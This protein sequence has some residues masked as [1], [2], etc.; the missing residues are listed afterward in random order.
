MGFIR[1][2]ALSRQ[3]KPLGLTTQS[4][5]TDTFLITSLDDFLIFGR[6]SWM[7]LVG[8]ICDVFFARKAYAHDNQKANLVVSFFDPKEEVE[9]YF[10]AFPFDKFPSILITFPVVV[11]NIGEQRAKEIEILFQASNG[12]IP[13]EGWITKVNSPWFIEMKTK[14]TKLNENVTAYAYKINYLGPNGAAGIEF[15][16]LARNVLEHEFDL[17]EVIKKR[18]NKEVAFKVAARFAFV[19]SVEIMCENNISQKVNKQVS[20]FLMVVK[21][22]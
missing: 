17:S 22:N 11:A 20:L 2:T 12:L 4:R 1:Q 16:F 13:P 5:L 9:T 14:K 8:E 15:P 18:F 19:F 21:K 3:T 10:F 6:V 7:G